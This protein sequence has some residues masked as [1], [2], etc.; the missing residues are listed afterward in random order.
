MTD[1]S[2]FAK[3]IDLYEEAIDLD[4]FAAAAGCRGRLQGVLLLATGPRPGL[5][6]TGGAGLR[7]L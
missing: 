2:I 3:E 7:P 1:P 5:F 4:V 6:T